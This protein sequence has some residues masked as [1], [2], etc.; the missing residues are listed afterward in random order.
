MGCSSLELDLEPALWRGGLF[1]C[2]TGILLIPLPT[3]K[4]FR[5]I[6]EED[7]GEA[8]LQGAAIE[9]RLAFPSAGSMYEHI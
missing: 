2:Q 7:L 4:R 5:S 1:S 6:L 9:G 8:H 3:L